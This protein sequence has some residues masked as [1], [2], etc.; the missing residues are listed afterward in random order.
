M[1]A[2]LP[3]TLFPMCFGFFLLEQRASWCEPLMLQVPLRLVEPASL[4][5]WLELQE[6]LAPCLKWNLFV[7]GAWLLSWTFI[8]QLHGKCVGV[9]NKPAL[10]EWGNNHIA[11]MRF[12][13]LCD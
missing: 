11:Y 5:E 1:G 4:E 9:S 2:D 6:D 3:S 10:L 7:N 8:L 12:L 13:C